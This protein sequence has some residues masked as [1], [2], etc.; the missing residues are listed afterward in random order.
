MT[1]LYF[2]LILI[3][4]LML[5]GG[6]FLWKAGMQAAGSQSF[7]SPESLL[8]LIFSPYVLSGLGLYGLA[9]VLWLYILA[10]VPLSLAYPVQSLAYV[11]A[12]VG[13]YYIFREPLSAAKLSGCALILAGVGLIAW[14]G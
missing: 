1:P 13:A 9:T 3:N 5:A 14:R 8:R 6:Q 10:R 4:T 2:V 7:G 12:V 11:V